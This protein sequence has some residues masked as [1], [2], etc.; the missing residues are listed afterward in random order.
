M[1]MRANIILE[2]SHTD[3]INYQMKGVIY[4][5]SVNDEL[6]IRMKTYYEAIP[7]TKLM[8]RCPVAVR[9]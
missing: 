1:K 8:R 6:G 2:I 5:M 4:P 7:K 9:L 3:Y